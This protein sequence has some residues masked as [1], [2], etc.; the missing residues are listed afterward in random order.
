MALNARNFAW[1][2][3]RPDILINL[4]VEEVYVPLPINSTAIHVY[5]SIEKT[6]LF[7]LRPRS[8]RDAPCELFG[9]KLLTESKELVQL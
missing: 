9:V 7:F 5:A 2:L 8:R 1:L 4:L 6:G 3:A